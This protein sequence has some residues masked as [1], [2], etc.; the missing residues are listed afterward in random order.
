[1][2]DNDL[3]NREAD[4]WRDPTH[5]LSMMVPFA[6]P[7]AGYVHKILSANGALTPSCSKILDLGCGA[8]LV[9]EQLAKQGYAVTGID[10]GDNTIAHAKAHAVEAGMN[11][12][13]RV[14]PGE[15]LPAES[16]T[17]DAVYSLD[18]LEHVDDLNR[19]ASE[20]ARVLK[21]GGLFVFDTINRT[22]ASYLVVLKIMQD[23]SVTSIMPANLHEWRRLV[24]PSELRS[25]FLNNGLTPK[26]FVGMKPRGNPLKLLSM[27]RKRKKGL[28]NYEQIVEYVAE[29]LE[30]RGSTAVSYAGWAVK[31]GR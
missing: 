12:D 26:E 16:S 22:L 4:R 28:L 14:G 1:M 5:P 13:Y 31:N 3:Y 10:P 24:K 7:R 21:P 18:V 9:A 30:F 29:R 23:W 2:I 17:Y 15:D 19:V 11:I 25:A 8:G 6:V 27:L 20:I